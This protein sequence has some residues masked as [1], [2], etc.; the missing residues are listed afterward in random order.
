[1]GCPIH[2]G[3]PSREVHLGHGYGNS[4]EVEAATREFLK[5]G[6]EIIKDS[7]I[8][9]ADRPFTFS[10][11]TRDFGIT[12]NVG[13]VRTNQDVLNDSMRHLTKHI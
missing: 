4:K 11:F 12:A 3:C 8:V 9:Y 6:G 5:S 7:N 1:M 10:L 2:E 13:T